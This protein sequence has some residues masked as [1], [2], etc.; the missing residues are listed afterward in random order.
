MDTLLQSNFEYIINLSYNLEKFKKDLN[1]NTSSLIYI[2]EVLTHIINDNKHKDF[3]FLLSNSIEDKSKSIQIEKIKSFF[4][5]LLSDFYLKNTDKIN[6]NNVNSDKKTILMQAIINKNIDFS[7]FLIE[8][9]VEINKKGSLDWTALHQS[10]VQSDCEDIVKVLLNNNSD[11]YSLTEHSQTCLHLVS[12]KNRIENLKVI[13]DFV[14]SLLQSNNE[15]EGNSL[16]FKLRDKLFNK[17]DSLQMTPFLKSAASFSN[18]SCFELIKFR[19]L[20]L[21]EW[22]FEVFDLN[23]KDF[24]GNTAFHYAF[25]DGNEDLISVLLKNKAESMVN[26]EGKYCYELSNN[27]ELKRRFI[28]MMKGDDCK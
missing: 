1:K 11:L 3:E 28:Q 16:C 10:V 13:L 21:D 14:Y 22:K 5:D 7:C 2:H 4:N 23:S 12:S 27:D 24:N 19:K 26:N 8:N 15:N 25:E 20:L 6:I 18:E 9:K 17:K